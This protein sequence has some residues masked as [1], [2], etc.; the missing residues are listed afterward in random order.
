M[1][2]TNMLVMIMSYTTTML[3]CHNQF[4]K[5]IQLLACYTSKQALQVNT[6]KLIQL[7]M[8]LRSLLEKCSN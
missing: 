8:S 3:E 7:V 1:A 4:E 5:Q 6:P 2:K